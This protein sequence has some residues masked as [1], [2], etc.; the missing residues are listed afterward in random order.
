MTTL[1]A[2]S[3]IK[4]KCHTAEGPYLQPFAPNPNWKKAEIFIVGLN[5]VTSLREEFESF[6]Q[7]WMA[8]TKEPTLY[9]KT[10]QAKYL[11]QEV[12]RSRTSLRIAELVDYLSPVNTLVTNVYAY[13]TTK[14]LSIPPQYRQ[15]PIPERI[16]S[17]LLIIC[18]PKVLL[19][20]G[21]EA[22]K[23]AN[24]YFNVK[25]DPY[26]PPGKQNTPGWIRGA[27]TPSRLFAY[28][29]LVGRVDT[30][31]EVTRRL[32]QFAQLIQSQL[33]SDKAEKIVV[34]SSSVNG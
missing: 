30:G 26:L 16:I 28:H 20:H 29:H 7:Y 24:I 6:D 13:P 9:E 32:K 1:E 15:E 5:P 19:F 27:P 34:G 11:K 10:Q 8:L 14:P 23:F 12:A 21:A 2:E 31:R 4:S 17:R 22:C 33:N 18:K 3:W 25:L